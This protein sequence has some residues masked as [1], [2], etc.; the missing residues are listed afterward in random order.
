MKTNDR[1]LI[2]LETSALYKL[3]TYLH[4]G[5]PSRKIYEQWE[6]PGGWRGAKK[7]TSDRSRWMRNTSNVRD[8]TGGTRFKEAINIG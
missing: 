7:V 1:K 6:S 5:P 2:L 3:F 8:G 4:G